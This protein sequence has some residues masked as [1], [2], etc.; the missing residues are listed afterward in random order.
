[1]DLGIQLRYVEELEVARVAERAGFAKV[2]VGDNMTDAF[3]MVGAFAGIT[4]RV[5]L[6]TS[7]A[8]W[9]R[10]PVTT[11][12]AA[13]T[14]AELSGGRF[15]LGIGSMPKH[16]S[17]D[18]HG[19]PYARKVGR[20]REF[21][22][23]IRAAWSA[24]PEAPV[25]FDGEFYSFHRYAPMAPPTGHRI[26]VTLGVIGPQMTRLAGEIAD[27]VCIDSMHTVPWTRDV[28]LP[29][30][31]E[32]LARAHRRRADFSVGV[33]LISAVADD[34]AEARDLARRTIGFYLVT[35]YLRDVLAHHGFADDYDRGAAA[36]ARGD[37]DG[38]AAAMH[39]EIVDA[40]A[41]VGTPEEVRQKLHER[42]DGLVDWV[43]V[44]PPH[45]NP[46]EVV[47]EQGIRL[48]EAYADLVAAPTERIPSN[49]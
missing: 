35:P 47:R 6:R 7:V 39:D 10:T 27:G 13:S 8:T 12:L 32:G 17:E 25:D 14:A 20:M 41:V 26:P 22:G 29:R 5:E 3:A 18:H 48:V 31:E 1:M 23:A 36:L 15:A 38:A 46:T 16:W 45:G 24:T 28:L 37:L 30:L 42:Y 2:C 43:R 4:E 49:R 33:A 9:T 21:V 11:A 44:S 34:V 19:I 40:I